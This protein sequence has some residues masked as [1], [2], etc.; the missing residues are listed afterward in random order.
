MPRNRKRDLDHFRRLMPGNP[1]AIRAQVLAEDGEVG[2]EVSLKHAGAGVFG[3]HVPVDRDVTLKAM[4][5]RATVPG[6]EGGEEEYEATVPVR[7]REIPAGGIAYAFV[8]PDLAGPDDGD[9]EQG[10]AA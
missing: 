5:L 10:E 2:P 8:R 4:R 7:A 3:V 9:G 6:G 1:G